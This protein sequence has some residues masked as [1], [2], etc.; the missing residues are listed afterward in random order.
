MGVCGSSGRRRGSSDIALGASCATCY[1]MSGFS[2]GSSW[3]FCFCLDWHLLLARHV[4]TRYGQ[5]IPPLRSSSSARSCRTCARPSHISGHVGEYFVL[6]EV[7]TES[8]VLC[9][10][11]DETSLVL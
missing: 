8:V 4:R 9:R 2:P 3:P 7:S 11:D 5:A 10:A 1:R 6:F